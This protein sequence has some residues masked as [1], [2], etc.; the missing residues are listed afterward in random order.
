MLIT[1]AYPWN[2]HDP[3]ETVEV[4]DRTG[5]K[6]IRYGKARPADPTP[7]P[8]V[9]PPPPPYPHRARIEGPPTDPPATRRDLTAPP[10]DDQQGAHHEW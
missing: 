7:P 2:G 4:D 6:L 5:R 9:A 8:A 10:G 1:L 3:D